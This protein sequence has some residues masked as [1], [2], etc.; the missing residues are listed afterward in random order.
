MK[1]QR[2]RAICISWRSCASKVKGSV[3]YTFPSRKIFKPGLFTFQIARQMELVGKLDPLCS[4]R[5]SDQIRQAMIRKSVMNGVDSGIRTFIALL[6][7]TP[8]LMNVPGKLDCH[9]L[10]VSRIANGYYAFVGKTNTEISLWRPWYLPFWCILLCE[11]SLARGTARGRVWRDCRAICRMFVHRRP[12]PSNPF[13][14]FHQKLL[15]HNKTCIH[16]LPCEQPS[17]AMRYLWTTEP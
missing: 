13:L 4:F 7:K 5:W 12:K 16:F 8:D 11:G 14:Y 2:A 9:C 6:S 10:R 17:M 1:D 15:A 3:L